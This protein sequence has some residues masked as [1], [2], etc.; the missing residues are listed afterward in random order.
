MRVLRISDPSQL[1]PWFH[2]WDRLAAGVPG[3]VVHAAGARRL[4]NTLSVGLPGVRAGDLLAAIGDRLAASAG[5]A[6]HGLTVQVSHVL[7]AMGVTTAVA[8]GTIRLSVGRFTT[9]DEVDR[10]A[11]IVLEAAQG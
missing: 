4:P 1:V 2:D 5:A 7:A 3:L 11:E 6:C 10:G 9:E 8:L